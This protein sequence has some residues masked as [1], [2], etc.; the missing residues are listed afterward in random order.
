MESLLIPVY[1]WEYPRFYIQDSG[2]SHLNYRLD[3]L[4]T[5]PCLLI[6]PHKSMTSNLPQQWCSFIYMLNFRFLLRHPSTLL[7]RPAQNLTSAM[8]S[9]DMPATITADRA[10]F[11]PISGKPKDG[12]LLCLR[13]F[14]ISILLRISYKTANG[15]HN[16]WGILSSD[17]ACKSRHLE[18]FVPPT[19]PIVYPI[20][21]NASTSVGRSCAEIVHKP[22]WHN[23]K[24]HEAAECGCRTL[25]RQRH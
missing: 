9:E 12:D 8:T 18:V 21:P 25:H 10:D 16:L 2:N 23:F 17:A 7:L 11:F 22:L 14:L 15:D 20:I 1:T 13:K 24:L 19:H 6:S 4:V 5:N 3:R